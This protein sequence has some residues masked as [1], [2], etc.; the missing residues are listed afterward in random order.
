MCI[1]VLTSNQRPKYVIGQ[2]ISQTK[3]VGENKICVLCPVH[4]LHNFSDCSMSKSNVFVVMLP[5]NLRT[6][7]EVLM[8]FFIESQNFR[9]MSVCLGPAASI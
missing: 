4:F 9:V 7:G 5:Y 3:V 6:N 1:S 2:E 8:N